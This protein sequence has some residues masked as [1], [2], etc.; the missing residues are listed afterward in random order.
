VGAALVREGVEFGVVS[1]VPAVGGQLVTIRTPGGQYEDVLLPLYGEHQA[2]NAAAALAAVES[3]V[4]PG[5]IL[6]IDVV[7]DAFLTVTSPGRLEVVRRG[8]TVLVDA[9]HNP[10]GARSLAI[11]LAESYSFEKVVAVLAVMADKDAAGIV[12][13]LA[14]VVDEVIVTATDSQRALSPTAL[15]QIVSDVLGEHRLTVVPHFQTALETAIERADLTPGTAVLVTGSIVA[16]GAAR[17]VLAPDRPVNPVPE[18]VSREVVA[19]DDQDIFTEGDYDE[20]ADRNIDLSSLAFGGQSQT[21]ESEFERA[22][23]AAH[24]RLAQ[25][26]EPDDDDAPVHNATDHDELDADDEDDE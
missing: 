15:A 23:N 11:A 26:S 8:P 5:R 1:R 17:T 13:G 20:I 6:A 24:Q 9:A 16:V 3:F 14:D 10:A 2:A 18:I 25:H 4:S 22:D 7:R 21:R 12:E 19:D